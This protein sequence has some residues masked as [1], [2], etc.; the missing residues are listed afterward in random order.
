MSRR[1]K[2]IILGIFLVLLAI[3]VVYVAISWHP[4]NSLQFRLKSIVVFPEDKSDPG[5]RR[6]SLCVVTV[7]NR[8]SFP[9]YFY[10]GEVSAPH[11]QTVSRDSILGLMF[12]ED[13]SGRLGALHSAQGR[14]LI[15]AHSEIQVTCLLGS[16]FRD[17][18]QEDSLFVQYGWQ[19]HTRDL[20]AEA[21]YWIWYHG[22]PQA[23]EIIPEPHRIRETAPL[24]TR[25][26]VLVPPPAPV[27]SAP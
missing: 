20:V 27:P 3:P 7:E 21:V 22:P 24:V 17:S 6:I 4:S 9:M 19:S 13:M 26:H 10:G 8:H 2:L 11:A 12:T 16:A 18:I 5:V 23:R 14:V 15:P 1:T 25:G